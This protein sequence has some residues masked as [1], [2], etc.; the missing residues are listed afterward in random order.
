MVEPRTIAEVLHTV[1]DEELV[2]EL[3][4]RMNSRDAEDIERWCNDCGH[5]KPWKEIPR[6][7]MP[8]SYNPCSKK[9]VMKFYAPKPH[10][11]PDVSGYYLQVCPDRK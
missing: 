4:R 6:V 9:H 10:D 8:D 1:T 7:E 3:A 2:E 11:G 5:F